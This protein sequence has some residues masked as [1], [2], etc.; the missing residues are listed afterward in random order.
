MNGSTGR[1]PSTPSG[2]NNSKQD[3]G[4]AAC[5]LATVLFFKR[6]DLSLAGYCDG[7]EVGPLTKVT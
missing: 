1:E 6:C 4:E 3:R 2:E 7:R 5:L